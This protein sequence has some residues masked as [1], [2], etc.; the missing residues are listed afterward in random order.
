MQKPEI[1]RVYRQFTPEERER[2]LKAR[3]EIE[4]E[5]PEILARHRVLREAAAEPTLSGAIRRAVHRTGLLLPQV[6]K[7]VGLSES[8]IHE[9]LL[10]ERTLRSDVL[11][12]LAR[13]VGF[14]LPDDLP[15][16]PARKVQPTV[17]AVVPP[18]DAIPA[19][20]SPTAST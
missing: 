12:R 2:W 18:L 7:E 3:A 1:R 15:P 5:M 6:A 17:M 20:A 11:D 10:G 16:P 4:A 9:F 14:D 13:A 8:E 19:P